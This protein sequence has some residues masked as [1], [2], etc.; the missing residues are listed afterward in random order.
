MPH[1]DTLL[2]FNGYSFYTFYTLMKNAW[3]GDSSASYH[4]IHS[5]TCMY[6]DTK[7]DE[8]KHCRL[9]NMK[10]TKKGKLCIRV[11]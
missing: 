2:T 1:A 9:V 6:D 7:V 8:L 11:R 3:I 4:I 5:D 10:A